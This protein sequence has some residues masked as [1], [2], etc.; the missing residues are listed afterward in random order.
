MD[1]VYAKKLRDQILKEFN[2]YNYKCSASKYGYSEMWIRKII[3]KDVLEDRIS[4]DYIQNDT[5]R[6]L[7]YSIFFLF[8]V[9]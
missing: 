4:F 3:N 2:G 7:K 8:F 5:T 1:D 9:V 6:Y